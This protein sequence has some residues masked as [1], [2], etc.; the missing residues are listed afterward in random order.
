MSTFTNGHLKNMFNAYHYE[1]KSTLLTG[2]FNVNL[3]IY[4]KKRSTYNFLELL[5]NHNF[6]PQI[7]LPTRVNEKSATLIDNIFVNNPSFKYLSGNIT[8]SISDHLPQFIILENFKGSNLKQERVSTTYR[9]FRYF[10][11]DS[12]KKDLQEINWNFATE[13]SDVDLGFETFFRLFNKALDRHAPIKKSTRKEEK[14]K[15]KPWITKGIKTSISIR[16]KLYKEMIKEKNVLTKVLKHE[17]FKKYWNQIINLLRVSKQTRYNNK[18]NC[19][20]TWAGIIEVIWPKNKKKLNFLTSLINKAKIMTNFKFLHR[21]WHRYT[22]ENKILPTKKYY[23]DYLLNPNKET[24]F[25]TSTT[26]E[27]VSDII[28]ELNIR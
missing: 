5:F 26:Y 7:T 9:H 3:I 18:K 24:F 21:N 4:D 14:I 8:T 20:A 15:S 25:I 11:I 1:N 17:S 28:S 19:R 10:N 27:E 22:K 16:D 23:I 12:F 6:T 2:D 13:N